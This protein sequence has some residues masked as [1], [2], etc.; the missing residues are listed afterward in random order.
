[1]TPSE[2]L[3][4]ERRHTARVLA[5]APQTELAELWR[6]WPSRPEVEYVRGPESGLVM[7][8]GRAGG[9]G[10][11]FNLGEATVT[12]ATVMVRTSAG[13]GDEPVH[14]ESPGVTSS[15][16]GSLGTAYVLGS[17]PEHAALAAIFD[18]LLGSAERPR[19]MKDV[20]AMLEERQAGHEAQRRAEARST[21]VDFF[22]VARENDAADEEA[23]A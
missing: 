4:E 10:D 8:Q 14:T 21:V 20:I 5:N 9:A 22:T 16:A 3:P 15:S 11:R 6:R 13:D 12:R 23:D 19:V 1:M 18:G 7:V 2:R 17:R